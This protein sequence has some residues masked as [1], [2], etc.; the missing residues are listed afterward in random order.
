MEQLHQNGESY[1]PNFGKA[2]LIFAYLLSNK[3]K[4]LMLFYRSY[5][6]MKSQIGIGVINRIY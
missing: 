1:G 3:T 5:I 2:G 4:R 6:D